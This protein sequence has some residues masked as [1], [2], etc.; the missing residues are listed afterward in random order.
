MARVQL[1]GFDIQNSKTLTDE[2]TIFYF[3]K[4]KNGD[5]KAKEILV[6]SNIKLVLSI[7]QKFYNK[8]QDIEDMFHVGVLGL[9]KAIDGFDVKFNVKFSTYAVP[10]IMGDIRRFAKDNVGIKVPRLLR[11]IAYKATVYKKEYEQQN[12]KEP[13]F[14]EVA[15]NLGISE[16]SL[17][18]AYDAVSDTI[19]LSDVVYSNGEDSLTYMDQIMDSKYTEE[20]LVDKIILKEAILN[21][22]NKERLVILLRYFHNKTQCEI[23][24]LMGISQAQVSR[25]E[26]AALL[27][28][29]NYINA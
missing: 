19:S 7:T 14:L 3:N 21:L 16:N 1:N 18:Q 9:I 20:K 24:Q 26:N 6:M 2:E 12:L 29:R 5:K 23:S 15:E 4:L 17:Y 11:D 13:T 25:L 28:M 22:P 27:K 10:M 8:K